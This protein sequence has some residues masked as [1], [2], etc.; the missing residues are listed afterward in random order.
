MGDVVA[1]EEG[2]LIAGLMGEGS[3]V[4]LLIVQRLAPW[5]RGVALVGSSP[6]WSQARLL[7][8]P[9]RHQEPLFFF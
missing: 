6:C 1:M 7:A 9:L 2:Q 8:L 4:E 3:E 5:P